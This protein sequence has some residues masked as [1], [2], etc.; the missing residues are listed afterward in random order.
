MKD[1]RGQS[2]AGVFINL[3]GQVGLQL[4]GGLGGLGG[5]VGA[6]HPLEDLLLA[7]ES[8]VELIAL[9]VESVDFL[10]QSLD[11]VGQPIEIECQ[12]GAAKLIR[13]I[14]TAK[15]LNLFIKELEL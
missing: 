13:G 1:H 5:T 4:L 11:L 14:G 8:L 9:L 7:A 2:E 12:R 3:E 6:I 15:F 10:G